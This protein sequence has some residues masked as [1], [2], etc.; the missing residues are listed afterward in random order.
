M[1]Q[2]SQQ[3][4]P[5]SSPSSRAPFHPLQTSQYLPQSSPHASPQTADASLHY[6]EQVG[7][8]SNRSDELQAA[9]EFQTNRAVALQQQM[10][11]AQDKAAACEE[12][13]RSDA[14]EVSARHEREVSTLQE[15]RAGVQEQL[16]T[17]LTSVCES[18]REAEQR[19][20]TSE[21]KCAVLFAYSRVGSS[22]KRSCR[23]QLARI[24]L[25]V[26]S[27]AIP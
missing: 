21:A 20:E 27:T 25:A 16:E 26:S 7:W 6:A 14:Q 17:Q 11:E 8:L 12:S 2:P 10:Q 24:L 1:H 13:A 4:Q 23:L 15:E 22:V 19:A 3:L 9:L 5:Q 18:A